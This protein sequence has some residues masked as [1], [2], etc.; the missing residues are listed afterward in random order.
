MHQTID[1]YLLLPLQVMNLHICMYFLRSGLQLGNMSLGRAH[2]I[3]T[4]AQAAPEITEEQRCLI[5]SLL[6]QHHVEAS[7]D[8]FNVVQ[9]MV[10]LAPGLRLVYRTNFAGMY[11]DISQVLSFYDML[12]VHSHP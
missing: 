9:Q 12:F 11:N 5:A 10:T 4:H 8:F 1:L 7:M 6:K 3:I 2:H